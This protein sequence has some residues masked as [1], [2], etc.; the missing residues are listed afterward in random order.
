MSW[1]LE[2]DTHNLVLAV[3]QRGSGYSGMSGL[4]ARSQAHT[5]V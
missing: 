1:V 3:S 4:E 5:A 2:L